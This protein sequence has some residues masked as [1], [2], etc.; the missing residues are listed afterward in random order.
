VKF[1][2]KHYISQNADGTFRFPAAFF[3]I[4]YY[5]ARFMTGTCITIQA[6][7]PVMNP[8]LFNRDMLVVKMVGESQEGELFFIL[9]VIT[10]KNP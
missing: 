9:Q 4:F 10:C 5:P 6:G 1:K 7:K 8:G 2:C 3:L